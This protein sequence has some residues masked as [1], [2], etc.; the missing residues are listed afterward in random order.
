MVGAAAIRYLLDY[1]GATPLIYICPQLC[2]CDRQFVECLSEYSCPKT[3]A[4]CKS[5]WRYFQNLF[6]GLGT[7]MVR[8]LGLTD[9]IMRTGIIFR[10][11]ILLL[12]TLFMVLLIGTNQDL[13]SSIQSLSTVS[14]ELTWSL[15]SEK[16]QQSLKHKVQYDD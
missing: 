8:I 4:M 9:Y 16:E 11:C 15:D 13:L 12:T 5:P 14:T 10:K 1:P 7:G 2:E 3:K 6:M